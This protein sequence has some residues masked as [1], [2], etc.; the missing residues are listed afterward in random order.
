M[1]PPATLPKGADTRDTAS[2]RKDQRRATVLGTFRGRTTLMNASTGRQPGQV[3]LHLR[4]RPEPVCRYQPV[5]TLK[6]DKEGL[7]DGKTA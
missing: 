7:E 1:K 4:K 6:P 3:K 2:G 5:G